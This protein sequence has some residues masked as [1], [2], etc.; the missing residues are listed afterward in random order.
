MLFFNVFFD[1]VENKQPINEGIL[2]I[3]QLQN[4]IEGFFLLNENIGNLLLVKYQKLFDKINTFLF[5][6][7]FGN[8]IANKHILT[9]YQ[10]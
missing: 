4:I 9:I 8:F 3:K 6:S 7:F 10:H 2:T 5:K 1:A